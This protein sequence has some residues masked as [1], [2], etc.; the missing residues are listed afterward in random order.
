MGLWITDSMCSVYGNKWVEIELATTISLP[1][2]SEVV[3]ANSD[4]FVFPF[5]YLKGVFI[6]QVCYDPIMF[7]CSVINSVT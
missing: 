7:P 3:L 6:K 2:V 1:G 4:T 5:H